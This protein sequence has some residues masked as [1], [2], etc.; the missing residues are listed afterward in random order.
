MGKKRVK[1]KLDLEKCFIIGDARRLEAGLSPVKNMNKLSAEM[2]FPIED[3]PITA[4]KN[5]Y[6]KI[7][8]HVHEGFYPKKNDDF[9]DM[10][11]E[12]LKVTEDELIIDF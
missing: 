4:I 2:W 10:I 3:E 6:F 12:I 9:T 11:C 1:K 7:Y 8:R 5:I